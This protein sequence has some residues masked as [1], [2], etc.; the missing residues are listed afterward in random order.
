MP[1]WDK[2]QTQGGG[3]PWEKYAAPGDGSTAPAESAPPPTPKAKGSFLGDFSNPDPTAYY[4]TLVPM[5]REASG[6]RR[7]AAPFILQDAVRA[8]TAPKRALTGEMPLDRMQSEARNLAGFIAGGPVASLA[9]REAVTVAT[10]ILGSPAVAEMAQK[11][12]NKVAGVT[13][14]FMDRVGSN[15]ENAAARRMLTAA[16]REGL[17]P[18]QVEARVAELGPQATLADALPGLGESLVNAPNQART[19]ALDFLPAR[20][21]GQGKRII[22]ALEENL[23]PGNYSQ[24][25]DELS[26]AR[27]AAAGPKYAE[28][29]DPLDFKPIK[30]PLIERLMERPVFQQ[31]LRK[32]ITDALDEAAITGQDARVYNTWLEGADL[33]DPNIVIKKAPTLRILDAAKRGLDSIIAGGG[34]EIRNPLNGRLTQRGMRIEQMRK[35]L[36]DELDKNAP[37]A[38]KQ[39]REAWAGPSRAMEMMNDG[40][41]FIK[42]GRSSLDIEQIKK[43]PEVDKQFMRIGA[44]QALNDMVANNPDGAN[45]VR[46]LFGNQMM[47][48][49]LEAI[50]PDKDSFQR[51]AK[52]MQNEGA[53]FENTQNMLRNSRTSYREALRE[54][55][56]PGGALETGFNLLSG[57]LTGAARGAARGIANRMFGPSEATANQLVGM[58]SPDRATQARLLDFMRQREASGMMFGPTPRPSGGLLGNVQRRPSLLSI[59]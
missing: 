12:G 20:Q 38:Y 54:D 26:R 23:T 11:A 33:N 22:S 2:Y 24:N 7:L 46:K 32:G 43:L 34:D 39:A 40:L 36:V 6:A 44:R 31:G 56:A 15:P 42:S 10:D 14:D 16:N 4:G 19:A 27:S 3:G 52:T 58:F 25:I 48:D 50:F 35:A 57:N 49:K 9:P 13:L 37:P 8:F 1:P 41:D 21:E 51:F 45:T 29:F 59:R 5:A 53:M 28:A 55:A 17:S 30:S 47:R 18:T